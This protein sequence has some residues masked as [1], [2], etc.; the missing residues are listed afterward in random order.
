MK[1]GSTIWLDK[2]FFAGL[3][4]PYTVQELESALMEYGGVPAI[5]GNYDGPLWIKP[6][7]DM[8]EQPT[9]LICCYG[10]V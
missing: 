1:Y 3:I 6:T 9:N 2:F 5:L 7:T 4:F 8:T 10:E